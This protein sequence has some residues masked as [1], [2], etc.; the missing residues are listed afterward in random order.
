MPDRALRVATVVF[1][2]AGLWIVALLQF[3][4]QLGLDEVEFFRATRWLAEGKVPYLDFWE[5]H[6]PLQWLLFAPVAAVADGPASGSIILMRWAQLPLWIAIFWLVLMFGRHADVDRPGLAMAVLL[7]VLS[8]TF[9]HRAIEYRVDVPGNLAFIGGLLAISFA[10]TRQR[11]IVFGALMSAAVLANM[12]LGPLV[13]FTGALTLFWRGHERRWAFN[14]KALWM[15]AGI[16]PVAIVFFT[17]LAATRSMDAFIEN[18]VGF[19]REYGRVLSVRNFSETLLIPVWTLD[20][21]GCMFW[22]VAGAG[23]WIALRSIREPG[24]LQVLAVV[25]IAGMF[26]IWSMHVVYDY[27]FQ[28]TWLLMVPLAGVAL[29]RLWRSMWRHAVVGVAVIALFLE[30]AKTTPTF[31][32]ALHYQ[33]S[34]MR[35]VDRTTLPGET[36]FDGTGYALRRQPAWRY[37]FLT[38]GVRFLSAEGVLE[39]YDAPQ[40]AARPPAA[41]ITDY[42]LMQHFELFPRLRSYAFRHYLPLYRDLWIPGMTALIGPAPRRFIWTVPRAGRYDAWTSDLLAKHPWVSR[43]EEFATTRPANASDFEIPLQELP[44]S[45][46]SLRWTVDGKPLPPGTRSLHLSRGSRVEL[47]ASAPAAAGVLLVPHGVTT[48]CIA[49]EGAMSF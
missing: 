43:R 22:I 36:V 15:A 41:I 14:S 40:M 38:T 13:M 19:N 10:T 4:L 47:T 25:A 42:R 24:P 11:W 18:V 2:L 33:D 34:L 45:A 28:N 30:V 17:G 5:H 35:A 3:G 6:T 20:L 49:P 8:S 46:A 7:V 12:R 31:G 29:E 21:A 9:V 16:A 48:L 44:P 32:A 39:R 23:S 1:V 37:W 27:H 26:A